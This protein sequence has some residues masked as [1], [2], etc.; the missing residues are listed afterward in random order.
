MRK[1]CFCAMLLFVATPFILLITCRNPHDKRKPYY[2]DSMVT[3]YHDSNVRV[4]DYPRS[5]T[6]KELYDQV[7]AL[8]E[9][10][11]REFKKDTI[12]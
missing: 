8:N 12:K 4:I 1:F 6:M 7:K 2:Q 11:E 3:I 9:M 10:W 5:D